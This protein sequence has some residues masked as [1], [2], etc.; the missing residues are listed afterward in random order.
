MLAVR[1]KL[2]SEGFHPAGDSNIYIHPQPNTGWSLRILWKNKR[3][4]CRARRG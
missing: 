1:I 3:K 2:P 4:D